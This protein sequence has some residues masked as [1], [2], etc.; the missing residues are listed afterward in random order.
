MRPGFTLIELLVVI[1]IVAVLASLLM[2]AIGMVRKAAQ[3]VS[4]GSNQRQI[5]MAVQ[6]YVQD[7]DGCM[8][9]AYIDRP[10]PWDINSV[11][12]WASPMMLGSYLD[13]RDSIHD[14]VGRST[15]DSSRRMIA[16]CPGDVRSPDPFYGYLISYGMNGAFCRDWWPDTVQPNRALVEP[17]A[18]AAIDR[19][20]RRMII[21]DTNSPRLVMYGNYDRVV[22]DD[23]NP[24]DTHARMTWSVA[25]HGGC[26]IGFL[27]GHVQKYPDPRLAIWKEQLLLEWTPDWWSG[28]LPF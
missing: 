17:L 1:T 25:R 8:P 27:D 7:Q 4:C 12:S 13:G 26:N 9:H 19:H 20:S 11:R 3:G 16:R 24:P 10:S 23:R 22:T 5:L 21:A 14:F 18:L 15:S 28:S 2:P 6:Q